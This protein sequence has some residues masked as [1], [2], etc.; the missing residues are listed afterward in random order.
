M[1]IANE[2]TVN[3]PV[4]RAWAVLT[5]LEQVVPLMPG[6]QMVG[7]E[8]EDFLGKLKV[9]VGPV[10]SEFTG[11]ANFVERDEQDH[12]A[13]IN[14]SGRDSRGSGNAA[15]TI[16][17]QLREDGDKTRVTVDTELR[18]VGKL[19]QFGSGM[20]QQVSEK[21]IREF[22]ASLEAKLAVG[23]SVAGAVAG[24]DGRE[25]RSQSVAQPESAPLDLVELVGPAMIKK[26]APAIAFVIAFVLGIILV[27]RQMRGKR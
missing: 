20:L 17:T 9:K 25:A 16:T 18:I 27:R 21:L 4:Q 13:V 11:K 14:G 23:D 1:K 7:W 24:P 12:R 15:A 26:Y 2:F 19:A 8:G 10:T 3:A 22:V 6:A 5:D